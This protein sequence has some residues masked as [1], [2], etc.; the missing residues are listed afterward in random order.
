[1]KRFGLVG[2][3]L[4]HSFSKKFFEEKF[5][6]MG[7]SSSHRYD[8]L[9]TEFLKDFP[10]LWDRY[11]DLVGVNVTVPH[12]INIIRFLDRLDS[13]ANKVEAVN[14][15]KKINGQ[16]IG[17]NTDIHGFK[18]SLK[19]WLDQLGKSPSEAL[20]LG[21]GG[22]SK[23]VQIALLE[24]GIDYQCVSR[25]PDQGDMLYTALER[26]AAIIEKHQL[27]VNT[28]P[29]G[30]HPNVN[31][32]PPIPYEQLTEQHLLFDLVYN[33]E[34]TMFMKEGLSRGAR[35]KNG[36]EMLHLQAEKSWEIWND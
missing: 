9:E 14:V 29:L 35:V 27:I 32:A 25:R 20:I 4:G 23:A 33:P 36:L 22:S 11:D 15:V 3:P 28:T 16:L 5:E 19:K 13:S 8:L 7:I 10:T 2:Y 12:K 1:M 21:T 31:D 17:F 34:E 26:D 24:L 18:I 30:M 6:K